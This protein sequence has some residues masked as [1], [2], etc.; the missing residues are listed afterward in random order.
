MPNILTCRRFNYET[1]QYA[2]PTETVQ[3]LTGAALDEHLMKT[4]RRTDS[5]ARSQYIRDVGTTLKE[6][7]RGLGIDPALLPGMEVRAIVTDTSTRPWFGP[8]TEA[9]FREG[10]IATLTNFADLVATTVPLPGSTADWWNLLGAT[11]DEAYE[12]LTVSQGTKIPTATIA[13]G[14]QSIKTEKVARGL[15]LTYEA[16]A[17]PVN[18]LQIWLTT[19]GKRMARTQLARAAYIL[20]NGY[21]ADNSDD[22]Q[23]VL[24]VSTAGG[25]FALIDYLTA[26]DVLASDN[27]YLPTDMLASPGHFIRMQTMQFPVSGELVF[28]NGLASV[29]ERFKV[30]TRPIPGFDDDLVIFQ[31]SGAALIEYESVPFGTE[32]TRDPETQTVATYASETGQFAP[33]PPEARVILDGRAR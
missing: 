3:V 29:E 32:D 23:V 8:L 13:I 22:A 15:Q 26:I 24:T 9:G 4:Y 21:Q 31:D 18:I 28:P 5:R 16:Q 14:Q 6:V 25:V 33:G 30:K 27:A 11:T 2:P 12:M 10:M 7:F 1:R 19:L 17:A 20:L